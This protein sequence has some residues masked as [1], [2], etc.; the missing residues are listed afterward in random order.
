MVGRLRRKKIFH[1]GDTEGTEKG[2]YSVAFGG[3]KIFHH[4][5]TESTETRKCYDA[6]GEEKKILN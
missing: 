6:C 1:H 2:K 5:D 4:G 3:K